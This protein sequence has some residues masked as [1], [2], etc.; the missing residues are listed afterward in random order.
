MEVAVNRVKESMEFSQVRRDDSMSRESFPCGYPQV[1]SMSV[2]RKNPPSNDGVDDGVHGP[3][4]V[5][6]IQ[7]NGGKPAF[8]PDTRFFLRAEAI[9]RQKNFDSCE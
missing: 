3:A 5:S 6:S 8:Q 7:R 1:G 4:E 9:G 2:N